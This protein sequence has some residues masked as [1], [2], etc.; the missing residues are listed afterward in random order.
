MALPGD[1]APPVTRKTNFIFSK[2]PP[3]PPPNNDGGAFEKMKLVFREKSFPEHPVRGG[4]GG[5]A[6][7]KLS[8]AGRCSRRA[9]Q[10]LPEDL[11]GACSSTPQAMAVPLGEW[12]ISGG[13]LA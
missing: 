9:P 8:F 6:T 1:V 7:A 2:A 13:M 11:R 3:L 4:E 5:V 12:H 10:P